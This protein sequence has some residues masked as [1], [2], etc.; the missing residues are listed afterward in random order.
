MTCSY[1][2]HKRTKKTH[3]F[4]GKIKLSKIRWMRLLTCIW[5][6]C[7]WEKFTFN[8]SKIAW[9][10]W[11]RWA[12]AA[13]TA[14]T[15][16]ILLMHRPRI[17]HIRN[18]LW[19]CQWSGIFA[20][21]RQWRARL[22]LFNRHLLLIRIAIFIWIRLIAATSAGGCILLE[23]LSLLLQHFLLWW[24]SALWINRWCRA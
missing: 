1:F 12:S 22:L 5:F 2:A 19:Q 11:S 23:R 20:Q 9:S 6:R 13:Q 8:W 7:V 10:C 4:Y 16:E 18:L 15:A 24:T 17:H 14:A 3:D 21:W